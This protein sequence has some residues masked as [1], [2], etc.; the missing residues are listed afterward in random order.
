MPAFKATPSEL[1]ILAAMRAGGTFL[2][3]TPQDA[4]TLLRAARDL[5]VERL[6]RQVRVADVMTPDP[7][8]LD[9]GEDA[10]DAARR[11]AGA[12][13]SGAPVVSGAGVLGV[14]SFRDFLAFLGI[15][16]NAPPIALAS[17]LLDGLAR[18]NSG[19]RR[20]RVGELMSA[21][22]VTVHPDA[23]AFEAARIMSGRGVNRLPAVRDGKLEGIVSRSDLVRAFGDLLEERP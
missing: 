4:G 18:G 15:T 16:P 3:I 22:A 14:I 12:R 19:T 8:V 21:P 7:L 1:D 11:L 2:D 17:A 10:R 23:S 9:P 13:V 6:H 20:P 5:T